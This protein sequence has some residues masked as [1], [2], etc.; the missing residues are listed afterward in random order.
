MPHYQSVHPNEACFKVLMGVVKCERFQIICG[1]MYHE[2]I[3]HYKRFRL[4]I[5]LWSEFRFAQH[6]SS[7]APDLES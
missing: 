4:A 2:S 6:A 1:L 7:L 5:R 3:N